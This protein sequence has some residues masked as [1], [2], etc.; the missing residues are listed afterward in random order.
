MTL[1]LVT[2][3]LSLIAITGVAQTDSGIKNYNV[4]EFNK[5]VTYGGG[6][7]QIQYSDKYTVQVHTSNACFQLVEISVSSKTLKIEVKDSRE[8]ICD[9]TIYVGVPVVDEIIQNGGG[10]IV[11]KEGFRPTNLFQCKINGGVD[12]NLL[13]LPVDSFSASIQGG[14]HIVLH[15]EK[16]LEGTISGGGL[17]EYAGDPKVTRSISGG[18]TIRKK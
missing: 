12:I 13:K 11:L 9:F 1:K 4:G 14:G 2:F 10:N 3:C 5:I 6:N 15:A 17:I 16:E 18:G 7:L 8:G